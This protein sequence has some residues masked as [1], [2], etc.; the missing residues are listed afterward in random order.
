MSGCRGAIFFHLLMYCG[1]KKCTDE[2]IVSRLPHIAGWEVVRPEGVGRLFRVFAF[3]D[4]SGAVAFCVQVAMLAEKADHHPM[5]VV[6]WGS[7]QVSWWSHELKGV[8]EKDFEM[9][10]ATSALYDS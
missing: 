9:A 5:M 3:D 2:E 10:E 6:E 8:S 7:V 1:M 4:F